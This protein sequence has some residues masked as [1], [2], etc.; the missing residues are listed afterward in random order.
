VRSYRIK[1][2]EDMKAHVLSEWKAVTTGKDTTAGGK[3]PL[4]EREQQIADLIRKEGPLSA[5]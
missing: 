5:E 4:T 2:I 1:N 3:T